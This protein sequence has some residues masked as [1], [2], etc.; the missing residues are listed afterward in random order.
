MNQRQD[1]PRRTKAIILALV[2]IQFFVGAGPVW[3]REFDWDASILWSYASIPLLVAVALLLHRRLGVR[4][5]LV[6]TVEITAVKFAVTAVFLTTWLVVWDVRGGKRPRPAPP[7]VPAAEARP[8]R[9]ET[10]PPAPRTSAVEGQVVGGAGALVFVSAGAEAFSFQPRPPPAQLENDGKGFRPGALAVQVGQALRLRSA[11]GRLHTLL[12]KKPGGTWVRNLPVPGGGVN[13][14]AFE[15]PV[16]LTTVECK[17][18][19]RAEGSGL[20]AI[21]DHPLWA[22]ADAEG[23]F[24]IQGVPPGE[25]TLTAAA[26]DGGTWHAPYRAEAGQRA[27]VVLR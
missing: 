26:L 24:T 20:L 14:V 19:G 9:V 12:A 16:G 13:E 17:V 1:L 15:D 23:R 25:G 2:V 18:H 22:V 10:R 5:W 6:D 7:P 11:D 27:P 3:Q 4:A 21:L 8:A